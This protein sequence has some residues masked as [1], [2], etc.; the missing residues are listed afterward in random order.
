MR[1]AVAVMLGS[2]MLLP[3][4]DTYLHA[5]QPQSVA[6]TLQVTQRRPVSGTHA[7]MQQRGRM[8]D[9]RWWLPLID[10]GWSVDASV[11]E[12][13]V[14]HEV[15]SSVHRQPIHADSCHKACTQPPAISLVGYC[16]GLIRP[17]EQLPAQDAQC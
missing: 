16:S 9:N 2:T 14:N 8:C 11:C 12:A 3:N 7:A 6:E 4:T 10:E 15:G 13:W 5:A 17:A 1:S